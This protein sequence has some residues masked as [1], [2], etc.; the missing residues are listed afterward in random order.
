M[1]SMQL[2]GKFSQRDGTTAIGTFESN[3]ISFPRVWL[4]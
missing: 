3:S 1:A 2:Y 4:P